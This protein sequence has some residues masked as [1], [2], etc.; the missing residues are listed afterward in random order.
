MIK[1]WS[2]AREVGPSKAAPRG[3]QPEIQSWLVRYRTI[4]L[5]FLNV[6]AT[7]FL[8]GHL[9]RQDARCHAAVFFEI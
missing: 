5:N 4:H 8:V 7:R 3:P 9:A 1:Y 2:I 6:E